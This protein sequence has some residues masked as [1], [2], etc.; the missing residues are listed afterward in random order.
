MTRISGMH[1]TSPEAY[2]QSSYALPAYI[3][4]DQ[5][6]LMVDTGTQLVKLSCVLDRPQEYTHQCHFIPVFS[7][8]NVQ[9]GILVRE[10]Q[11][12]GLAIGSEGDFANSGSDLGVTIVH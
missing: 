10:R 11:R 12:V 7:Q 6:S 9:I 8:P 3:E 4:G 5:D 2:L 1:F